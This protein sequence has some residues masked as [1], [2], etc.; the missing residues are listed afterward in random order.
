VETYSE[1]D[2]WPEQNREHCRDDSL[3]FAKVGQIIVRVRHDQAH[4]EVDRDEQS[5]AYESPHKEP[6]HA[7]NLTVA[8]P[9]LRMIDP[10]FPLEH[11]EALAVEIPGARTG[12]RLPA[13]ADGHKCGDDRQR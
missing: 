3:G 1:E 12:R 10:M 4:N 5:A 13:Q 9:D 2:E 11:G 6:A 8:G 7:R